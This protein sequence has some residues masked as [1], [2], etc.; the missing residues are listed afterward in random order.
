MTY[1]SDQKKIRKKILEL[2]HKSNSA[3]VASNLSIV[4]ILFVLAISFLC[5]YSALEIFRKGL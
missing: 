4:D 1:I 2:T 5:L 3:H